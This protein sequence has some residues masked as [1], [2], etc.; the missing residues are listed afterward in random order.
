MTEGVVLL[1]ILA[2]CVYVA[3]LWADDEVAAR[4]DAAVE[5]L[6]PQ[7][8]VSATKLVVVFGAGVLAAVRWPLVLGMRVVGRRGG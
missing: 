3:A 2:G 4:R 1:Y 5:S 6:A 7:F 8:G